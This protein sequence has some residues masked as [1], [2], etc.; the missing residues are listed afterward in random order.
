M[1]FKSPVP[2]KGELR[3]NSTFDFNS[4]LFEFICFIQLRNFR[5][6]GFIQ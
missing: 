1:I 4:S 6:I 2:L 5:G 3:W